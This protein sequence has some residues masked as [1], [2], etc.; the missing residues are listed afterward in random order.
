[1]TLDEL[2]DI[3]DEAADNGMPPEY[4]VMISVDGLVLGIESVEPT[5][6]GLLIHV[7]MY[8]SYKE[9]ESKR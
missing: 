7:D 9:R 8:E 4:P 1:M 3:T 2:R 6:E 5:S